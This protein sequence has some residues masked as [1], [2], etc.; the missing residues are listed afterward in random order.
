MA[1]QQH[2]F[3]YLLRLGDNCL[4]LGHRLSEWCGH[5]P[6]L[7]EDLALANVALD[8]IGQ[9]RLWLTLA[10]QVEGRGRDE[11]ALTYLRDAG[12]FRN[13]LL[14]EQPNGHYGYTTA[15]QFYFD[16]WHYYLLQDLS[17][18]QY[19]EIIEIAK[20]SLKEVTYHLERSS[21]W[22]ECLGDGTDESH[23]RMQEAIDDLWMYTGE[24]FEMDTVD[25][26]LLAKGIAV[27]L[28]S[29]REPW[30]QHVKAT[31][32]DATLTLPKASWMQQGGK[33]GVHSEHLGYILAEMQFLQR[34]YPNATW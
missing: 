27:D 26:A 15:R 1:E 28:E 17:K 3:E 16:A 20:K 5:G 12:E 18:S 21:D 8:L 25:R 11:D 22:V 7:E 31:L 4:I 23:Q 10:G 6:A 32:S 19:P 14:V 29:L 9:T 34:A 13:L 24:L 2:L 30:L 33:H